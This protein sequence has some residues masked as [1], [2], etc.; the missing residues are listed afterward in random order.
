MP[1]TAS[2]ASGSSRRSSTRS[3]A[4]ARSSRCCATPRSPTSWSTGRQ[5]LRRAQRQARATPTSCSAT[6]RT[7]CR[8][9]T[10]SSRA[11]GRRIDESSPMVDARLPDGSRVNAIIPPLALDGPALSIRRFGTRP[12]HARRPA[13]LRLAAPRPMARAAQGRA[14]RPRLNIAHLAAA[15]APARRRCSTACRRS[16]RQRAH[17]HHR[18]LGRAPAPAA[19]RRAGWRRARRT[20]KAGARSR[21]ATWCATRCACGPTASSSARS[22]APRRSTCSRP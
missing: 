17:R 2:S 15:P 22:A 1:L 11:V 20:S 5:G 4:S 19:A 10:A 13:R 8:S 7:C 14:C 3:S 9:S 12:A 6:T 18:G 16:S 21:S